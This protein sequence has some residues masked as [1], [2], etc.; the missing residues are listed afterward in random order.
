MNNIASSK[1]TLQE[2]Y[3]RPI[4]PFLGYV[5]LIAL[6]LVL[7]ASF[8]WATVLLQIPLGEHVKAITFFD[9]LLLG[10]ATYKMSYLLTKDV[11]TS[12]LR[13]PFTRF[14]HAA[15][16]DD[17]QETARGKGLQRAIGELLSCPWCSAQW[18]VAV[19]FYAFILFPLVTKFIILLFTA[20]VLSDIIMVF[21]QGLK[22]RALTPPSS[23]KD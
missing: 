10:V 13:A 1:Q 11:I 23:Q 9:L 2:Q 18:I 4:A 14:L 22:V 7:F 3:G 12:V 20:L 21:Y 5:L 15:S 17:V 8:L 19:L 6:F 16:P